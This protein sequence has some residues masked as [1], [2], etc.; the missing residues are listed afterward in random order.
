MK[1]KLLAL[2][3]LALPSLALAQSVADANPADVKAG[4]YTVEPSHTRVLFAVSHMGF[5]TWYGDFTN[6]SGSLN[7]DP[8]KLSS[9][10]FDITIPAN[11]VSTTNT[12]LDGELNSPEW[13]DTAKY[14]TIEFKSEKVVRTGKDTALVTGEL[15]FHGVTKPETLKVT[16]NAAGVNPLSKQYTVGFNATGTLKRSDFNQKTYV[17]L[18][19]DDVTL[20]IS[21]AFVQ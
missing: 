19:G 8:A 4:A 16:F 10:S 18:I 21:A 7:L 3:A 2:A 6:V 13:F 12:K 9:T 17:P 14:P 5:T 11:T 1:T 20:T 15:T